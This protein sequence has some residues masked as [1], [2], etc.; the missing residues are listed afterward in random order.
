MPG[1][2][3]HRDL[4][5]T[6]LGFGGLYLDPDSDRI[7]P[8]SE[9]PPRPRIPPAPCLV[10]STPHYAV[11]PMLRPIG[12]YGRAPH[13]IACGAIWD[14][15]TACGE[16]R[17][18]PTPCLGQAVSTTAAHE[19]CSQSSWFVQAACPAA[20]PNKSALCFRVCQLPLLAVY[21]QAAAQQVKLG[22][23]A[24][25]GVVRAG[26]ARPSHLVARPEQAADHANYSLLRTLTPHS[27]EVAPTSA[28]PALISPPSGAI[29]MAQMELLPSCGIVALSSE[30]IALP[31]G[32]GARPVELSLALRDWSPPRRL[33]AEVLP[34]AEAWLTVLRSAREDG[35]IDIKDDCRLEDCSARCHQVHAVRVHAVRVHAVRVPAGGSVGEMPPGACSQS[36]CSQSACSQSASWRIGRR[37]ATRCMKVEPCAYKEMGACTRGACMQSRLSGDFSVKYHRHASSSLSLMC[38][39]PAPSL[40]CAHP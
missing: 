14:R 40:S 32:I 31:C 33:I 22:S 36:A 17:I 26:R 2:K 29:G 27:P 8:T 1:S 37:D 6:N 11:D 35:G 25:S 15:P 39:R 24:Q 30:M 13:I 18:S 38:I 21:P 28:I 7:P 4:G 5:R 34:H 12:S 3:P 10:R 23:L 19:H 20:A 9:T 16:G